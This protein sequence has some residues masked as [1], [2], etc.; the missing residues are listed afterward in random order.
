MARDR[1]KAESVEELR[2]QLSQAEETLPAIRCGDVDTPVA[3]GAAAGRVTPATC[4]VGHKA[5]PIKI[6]FATG[7]YSAQASSKLT[8]ATPAKYF[9][10]KAKKGQQLTAWVIGAG[11]TRGV[12]TF[13]NGTADG[14]PGGKIFE[15][16][17][18]STGTILIRASEDTMANAWSGK[19]TVLVVII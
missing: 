4:V 5:C 13:A 17:I 19:V 16:Q 8:G 15:G 2:R 6:V 12:V 11:P 18:P 7:A 1:R 10:V 14:G 3:A 9:S